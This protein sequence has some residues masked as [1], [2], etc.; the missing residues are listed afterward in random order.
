[1]WWLWIKAATH[2][3]VGHVKCLG[4]RCSLC[5]AVLEAFEIARTVSGRILHAK[6][7]SISVW[8][9]GP[10]IALICWLYASS[11]QPANQCSVWNGRTSSKRLAPASCASAERTHYCVV[12]SS[13]CGMFQ[14]NFSAKGVRREATKWLDKGR[15]QLVWAWTVC[16]PLKDEAYGWGRGTVG[17]VRQVG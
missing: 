4:R 5:S 6:S 16:R 13:L 7:E 12:G 17:T 2:T 14:Y 9:S 15:W 11:T 10:L 3:T 1:M 8:G